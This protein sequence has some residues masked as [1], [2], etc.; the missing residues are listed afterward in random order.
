MVSSGSL[1]D[2]KSLQVFRILLRILVDLNN[3]VVWMVSACFL[4][5]K[6][7]S[8]FTKPLGIVPSVSTS[9]SWSV[10]FWVFFFSFLV[11]PKYLPLFSLSFI[12]TLWFGG[13]GKSTTQQVFFFTIT[14][15]GCRSRLDDPFVSQN[16]R[17]FCVSHSSGQILGC[18][19]TTC[20]Y[21]QI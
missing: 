17:E 19:C 3:A 1:S 20:S 8:T 2:S 4:I 21:G 12:S 10:V 7:S 16:P 13:T 5:S 14:R 6:S 18:A 11:R 9:P 15:S